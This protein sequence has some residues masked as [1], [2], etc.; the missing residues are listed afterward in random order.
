MSKKLTPAI[1]RI[2]AERVREELKK[3]TVVLSTQLK[4]KVEASKEHKEY[5][6]LVKQESEIQN[7]MKDLRNTIESRYSIPLAHVSLYSSGNI[8]I[9]DTKSSSVEGI[10][11]MILV[12][13][14]LSG[15]T[16][17][18]EQLVDKLVK[19]LLTIK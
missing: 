18:A 17:T 9:Y 11:D 4:K 5:L 8:T 16:E 14:Y 6:K 3:Q 15:G 12:E 13:D 2:L 10:R 19:K 1:A 7:K